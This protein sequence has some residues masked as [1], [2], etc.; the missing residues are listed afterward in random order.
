MFASALVQYNSTDKSFSTNVRYRWEYKLGS[1]FF[2]VYT[3]E[4][5]T[6]QRGYPGLKNRA[7]V[8][9]ATR[10]FRLSRDLDGSA[11]HHWHAG[12]STVR[13]CPTCSDRQR[14]SVLPITRSQSP[15]ATS[16]GA[17]TTAY[18][19]LR[20]I[21]C[22]GVLES[23]LPCDSPLAVLARRSAPV[24][25]PGPPAA[26]PQGDAAGR[27]GRARDPRPDDQAR[28]PLRDDQQLHRQ[29]RLPRGAR[30]PAAPGRRSA[31]RRAPGAGPSR[32]RP[33]D[34]RR[35]PPVDDH[36]A[37][38][39]HDRRLADAGVR[40]RPE[41][42]LEAQPRLRRR[43]DALRPGQRPGRADAGR[44]R[45]ADASA[46]TPTTAAASPRSAA[47]AICCAR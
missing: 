2:V 34:S 41:V 38:L 8:V 30:V 43:P 40:R 47:S 1:E 9:K 21:R 31:A 23:P 13:R 15:M 25:G 16:A 33:A 14:R 5:D 46:P 17:S 3:D 39:G 18:D 19:R 24:D 20:P 44:L 28:H 26:R 22:Q 4:R 35:L 45:R 27:P 10:F 42:G 29:G 32:L 6:T 37:V 12:S 36:Q 11:W 7:F